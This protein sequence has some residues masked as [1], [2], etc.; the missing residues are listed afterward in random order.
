MSDSNSIFLSQGRGTPLYKN[1]DKPLRLEFI[2]E[3]ASHRNQLNETMVILGDLITR[4]GHLGIGTNNGYSIRIQPNTPFMV[5]NTSSMDHNI[6]LDANPA[7][8][9]I[10]YDP[11]LFENKEQNNFDPEEF[12][13]THPVPD[14]YVDTLAKWYSIKFTYKDFN[15]IFVRPGLGI[16]I[17]THLMREEHWE[18]LGGNPI[19]IVGHKIHYENPNG[20]KFAIPFGEIHTIINSS[21]DKWVLIK[22]SYKGTF[23]EEDIIRVY[24]PNNYISLSKR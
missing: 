21:K 6:T 1:H 5:I 13:K 12:K 7:D 15:Y 4:A 3:N 11:Y 20:T 24:N 23:D 18:V 2:L 17:Q 16:S 8:L 10:L 19:I 14:G 22:E 9:Q